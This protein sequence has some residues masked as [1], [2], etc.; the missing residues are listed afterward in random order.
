MRTLRIIALLLTLTVLTPFAPAYQLRIGN[1]TIEQEC[2]T[3][4]FFNG[5]NVF[6]SWLE[7]TLVLE[8]PQNISLT[9]GFTQV[10]YHVY[11]YMLVYNDSIETYQF[12]LNN[13][14]TFYGFFLSK[15]VVCSMP[16]KKSLEYLRLSFSDPKYNVGTDSIPEEIRLE[17][18]R[19][20]PSIIVEKVVPAYETWFIKKYGY[21]ASE[22]SKLGISVTAAYFVMVEFIKYDEGVLPR[23]IEEVI[24][25]RKGDCDDMTRIVVE[26]LSYY[27]IPAAMVFNNVY[28]SE[29]GEISIPLEN[30]TYVFVNNGPH[31]FPMAYIP[32]VGWLS[33]D[34]LAGSLLVYPAVIWG[35]TRETTTNEEDIK[36][37]IE[38]H[39]S[40]EAVQ[41][42]GIYGEKYAIEAGW[43]DESTAIPSL[44]NLL[45]NYIS[46]Y[47]KTQTTTTDYTSTP[48]TT[49]TS[50][51]ETT[52]IQGDQTSALGEST[53]TM[54]LNERGELDPMVVLIGMVIVQIAVL[55]V[56]IW[57]IRSLRH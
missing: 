13:G 10:V 30:V 51:T 12:N 57:I 40:I 20:P 50:P 43:L 47:S 29:L 42:I 25:T 24:E 26:L 52:E 55:I 44:M 18:I 39:R 53:N 7:T 19:T 22:A 6:N 37:T 16:Y 31:A 35:V 14:S 46:K 54:K 9:S 33:L 27:E 11:S 15:V 4:F 17:Y 1:S 41:V 2:V 49:P 34:F 56:M 48:I 36:E 3:L 23:S 32:G 45:D 8:T 5:I 28:V 38:L 21:P